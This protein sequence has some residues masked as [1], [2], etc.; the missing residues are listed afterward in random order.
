MHQS[1]GGHFH[2]RRDIS[3][4]GG[5][6]GPDKSFR[7]EFWGQAPSV[8]H[9]RSTP[10]GASVKRNWYCVTIISYNCS[11]G[12]VGIMVSHFSFSTLR[13]SLKRGE[14]TVKKNKRHTY[15][16]TYTYIHTH[17]HTYAYT[18]I[19]TYPYIHIHIYTIHTCMYVCMHACMHACIYAHTHIHTH[20]HI[21]QF[22]VDYLLNQTAQFK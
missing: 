14:I 12:K 20:T 17:T 21:R 7:D 18:Y 3:I 5:R 8:S 11:G 6:G 4:S 19:H 10:P 22:R 2:I 16:Y 13:C 9:Y 1:Q 15:I